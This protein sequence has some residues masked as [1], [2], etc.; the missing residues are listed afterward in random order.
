M[1]LL[2]SFPLGVRNFALREEERP[3]P[4]RVIWKDSVVPCHDSM[5]LEIHSDEERGGREGGEGRGRR[6]GRGKKDGGRKRE[7]ECM[8]K[9]E[10]ERERDRRR[11][12]E[13]ERERERGI[14]NNNRQGVKHVISF[15]P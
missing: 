12:K 4:A 14:N 7:C 1:K 15:P 5:S 2:M 3:S 6:G 9:R 11:S 8:C 10:R 13:A